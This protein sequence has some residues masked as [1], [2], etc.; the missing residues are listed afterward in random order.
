MSRRVAVRPRTDAGARTF[1]EEVHRLRRQRGL[2]IGGLAM[3]TGLSVSL[4]GDVERGRYTPTPRTVNILV[5]ALAPTDRADDLAALAAETY[6]RI[7]VDLGDL[8]PEKVELLVRL[9]RR[10]TDLPPELVERLNAQLVEAG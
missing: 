5:D 7:E 10:L 3:R 8:P 6:R 9:R 4:I 2:T 1:G